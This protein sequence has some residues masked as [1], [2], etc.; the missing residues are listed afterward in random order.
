MDL[1]TDIQING[2]TGRT[3][4]QIHISDF[5]T[6]LLLEQVNKNINRGLEGNAISL[7]LPIYGTLHQLQ[8]N[9]L[10]LKVHIER[11]TR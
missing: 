7:V 1:I 9:S 3:N 2:R 4:W 11:L 6:S 8:E 5:K 10:S